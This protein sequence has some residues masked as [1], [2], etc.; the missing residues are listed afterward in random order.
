M[1]ETLDIHEAIPEERE[2]RFKIL[3]DGAQDLRYFPSLSDEIV[4][5]RHDDIKRFYGDHLEADYYIARSIR[6]MTWGALAHVVYNR[7]ISALVPH[8]EQGHSLLEV[9]GMP[10]T[11]DFYKTA[12][13]DASCLTKEQD[14]FTRAGSA[15]LLG[16]SEALFQEID[17]DPNHFYKPLL[18]Q[19]ERTFELNKK[20]RQKSDKQ[21]LTLAASYR[22]S[23]PKPLD[24]WR[25]QW[26]TGMVDNLTTARKAIELSA[27]AKVRKKVNMRKLGQKTL[28]T[29]EK[30]NWLASV[31]LETFNAILDDSHKYGGMAKTEPGDDAQCDY[32][33][34]SLQNQPTEKMRRFCAGQYVL[35]SP[36]L[37]ERLDVIRFFPLTGLPPCDQGAFDTSLVLLSISKKL[38]NE[39]S[40]H[41]G[42]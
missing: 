32:R 37:R 29:I 31:N 18:R 9:A 41:K 11:S 30:L 26:H 23:R 1:S 15:L 39:I 13:I 36:D 5:K 16:V 35:R 10:F 7:L 12:F 38:T 4:K 17:A 33:H 3:S 22:S 8:I 21:Q 14:M 6:S 27:R 42:V 19:V 28:S 20:E 25:E 34:P 40:N 24:S 2:E